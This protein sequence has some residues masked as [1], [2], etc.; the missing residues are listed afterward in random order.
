MRRISAR[1]VPG[2]SNSCQRFPKN[3]KSNPV[4]KTGIRRSPL[5]KLDIARSAILPKLFFQDFEHCGLQIDSPHHPCRTNRTGK[6][7]REEPGTGADVGNHHSRF[8]I[9][10]ADRLVR[11]H[12]QKP[13]RIIQAVSVAGLKGSFVY[14]DSNGLVG[15]TG[16]CLTRSSEPAGP[17]GLAPA[18]GER[19]EQPLD[20]FRLAFRALQVTV[21]VLHP[22]QHFKALAAPLA[23]KFVHGHSDPTIRMQDP[24]VGDNSVTDCG[25]LHL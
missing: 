5:P 12:P 14:H 11:G 3:A 6:R 9:Q 1:T 7:Q 2:S 17:G 22:A 16:R 18:G 25:E 21:G 19:R 13:L 10:S 15:R 24:P 20:F 8:E 4:R 23:A